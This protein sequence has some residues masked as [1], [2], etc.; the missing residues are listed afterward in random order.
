MRPL[1]FAVAVALALPAVAASQEPGGE[2]A[3]APAP[4]PPPQGAPPPPPSAEGWR[5]GPCPR[6]VPRDVVV[7]DLRI[8]RG[9]RGQATLL[10]R[11]VRTARLRI[12]VLRGGRTA[13]RRA[14]RCRVIRVALGRRH[15]Q[16]SMTATAGAT[17]DRRRFPF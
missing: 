15:G 1:G 9:A 10:V 8:D 2:A 12:R 16:I 13:V 14:P 11:T 5:P 3:P 17:V 6:G 7:T 4:A